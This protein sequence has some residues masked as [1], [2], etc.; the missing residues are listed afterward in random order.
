MVL[1]AG[2][3]I[4]TINNPNPFQPEPPE[5]SRDLAAEIDDL[6]A[7]VEILEKGYVN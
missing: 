4:G 6:K 2:K 3:V 1:E 7:K 5:P